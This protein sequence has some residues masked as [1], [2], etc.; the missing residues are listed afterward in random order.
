MKNVNLWVKHIYVGKKSRKGFTTSLFTFGSKTVKHT[1]P[2]AGKILPEYLQTKIA[3]EYL[4]G[5]K[6]RENASA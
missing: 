1:C 6:R 5:E 4:I 2:P 3:P